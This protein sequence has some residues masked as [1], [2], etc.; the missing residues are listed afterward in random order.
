MPSLLLDYHQIARECA[1]FVSGL[2]PETAW[3]VEVKLREELPAKEHEYAKAAVGVVL[4]TA[5]PEDSA[6]AYCAVYIHYAAME[7]ARAATAGKVEA[8]AEPSPALAETTGDFFNGLSVATLLAVKAALLKE[9]AALM[10]GD[11]TPEERQGILRNF[12][13]LSALNNVLYNR[14]KTSAAVANEVNRYGGLTYN[15]YAVGF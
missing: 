1:A 2:S 4:G 9:T 12:A 11:W 10:K 7:A 8:A 14:G 15:P 5:S 3:R 6:L 13:Y